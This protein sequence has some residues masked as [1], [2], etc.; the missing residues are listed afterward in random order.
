M[1][2]PLAPRACLL[3]LLSLAAA[4]ALS[5]AALTRLQV[6]T[7]IVHA[8]PRTEAVLRDAMTIF[9][10]HPVH[11]QIA[12][13]LALDEAAP[14]RLLALGQALE[15]RM[16]ASGLFAQVG[17][18]EWGDLLP[19]LVA[20][21]PERL[22]HLLGREELEREVAPRLE[23]QAL[24]AQVAACARTLAG[25]EGIGQARLIAGDPLNL[26]ELLLAK[27]A[28]LAPVRG[29]VLYRGALLSRDQKHL[30]VTARPRLPGSDTGQ[31]RALAAFF[32]DVEAGLLAPLRAQGLN[33]QCTPMGAYRAAL[34]NE[35][36]VRHDVAFALLLSTFGIALLLL[37]TFPRPWLGLL[38]LVPSLVGTAAALFVYSLIFRSVSILVLGFGGALISITVDYGISYLLLLD[39]RH[40]THGKAVA[41]ELQSI[42]GRIAL[43]TTV[44]AFLALALSGFPLFAELGLFTALGFLGTYLFVML[45]FPKI[46]P[47]LPPGP[48]RP[49]PL[50]TLVR[51]LGSRG[52]AG[53][54]LAALLLLL[55]LPF[56]KPVFH[57]S[58][59]EM[60]SVR[61]DTQAAEA[62]FTK[63]WGDMGSQ[64]AL[65][66]R[67]DSLER[68]QSEND[69]LLRQLAEDRRAER[70]G[71]YF[72]PAML[73]PGEELA[74]QH[75]ADWRAFWTPERVQSVQEGLAEAGRKAGFAPDA[76]APFLRLLHAEK[77]PEN[78]APPPGLLPLLGIRGGDGQGY[79]QFISVRPGPAYEAAAFFARYQGLAHIFDG[80]YFAER[81]G[82]LL[83]TSFIQG[84]ALVVALVFFFHLVFSLNLRL[85]LLT[86]LPP[87]FAFV[88]TLGTLKLLGHPLDIPALMLAIV[89]FGM[90]DDYA[91]YTV[92]GFQHY[93]DGDHPSYLLARTTVF[94]SA[95][96]T[97]IGFGVL[98][99]A[100]H[101]LLK[102]V[103]LTSLLGVGYSLLGASLLLPPLLRHAFRE[104]PL[105]ADSPLRPRVLQHFRLLEAYPRVFA[106]CKL[107][108]D[109]MFRDLPELLAEKRD[110]RTIYDIG[111]GFG[112]PAC[113]AL[114]RW[115]GARI[116][117]VDP[118]P[119]RVH[120]ASRAVGER[121][122]IR[123][124][125]ATDRPF[126]TDR[127]D[128]VL[129]LDMLH[130]LDEAALEKT[131][132]QVLKALAPGGLLLIRHS[133]KPAG[134][135]SWRWHLEERRVRLAGHATFYRSADELA[136]LLRRRNCSVLHSGPTAGD[137]ELAWLLCQR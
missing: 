25:M 27:M 132:D 46:F 30:L 48:A 4:A 96:S 113:W 114:E 17:N 106:R 29:A 24:T 22:P 117:G 66:L 64:V 9:A 10:S 92:Y 67:A 81:L 137:P 127:A 136:A 16:R 102:S 84:L 135:R 42:G 34:D 98:C 76:F 90:G 19:E 6:D 61:P 80:P 85:S 126:F 32:A 115:P 83:C 110:I 36:V 60:N 95:A 129:L 58:L 53:A 44:G 131:L 65:M 33:P 62:R 3:L 20:G 75:L 41:R 70:I 122:E 111:C 123:C 56:A 14:D 59:Q 5:W 40:E 12:V 125:W 133:Q 49:L 38:S 130:Y 119:E 57:I 87:F 105:P 101:P 37:F 77:L 2:L 107:A 11:D 121:G 23:A 134:P 108:L 112:V 18:Q 72:A 45:V 52:R 82:H 47:V 103:G 91:V 94:M 124:G 13:D 86:M 100:E 43:L 51:W 54:L 109:P 71:P 88:C 15:A 97:L 69:R 63:I 28:P 26:R 50:R 89:I 93:R 8:M 35:E 55:L 116:Y 79:A 73:F 120:V 21:L 31:A 99:C 7:D 74:Q 104:K 1:R 118:D 68:M 78:M 128:L 39:R